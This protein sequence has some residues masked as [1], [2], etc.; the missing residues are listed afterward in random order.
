VAFL[1]WLEARLAA[2]LAGRAGDARDRLADVLGQ[3]RELT[4]V[5]ERWHRG[6]ARDADA[7][8]RAL[9]LVDAIGDA[10]DDA[11]A[12]LLALHGAM[13]AFAGQSYDLATLRAV[14]GALDRYVH[15][16]LT[17]MASLRGELEQA[18]G[19]LAAPR[20]GRALDEC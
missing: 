5:L 4:R 8:R 10:I 2:Q 17:G 20:L 3:V 13:V 7:G 15:V 14:L 19:K 18:L 6:E 16:Y 9:H 11:A 12:E 1:E